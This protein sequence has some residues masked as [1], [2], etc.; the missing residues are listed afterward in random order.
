MFECR[1]LVGDCKTCGACL[2]GW[3]LLIP[4]RLVGLVGHCKTGEACWINEDCWGEEGGA[5]WIGGDLLECRGLVG[6]CKTCGACWA[7]GAF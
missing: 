4:M 7:G 1:G 6:A 3:G 2:A 5:Y